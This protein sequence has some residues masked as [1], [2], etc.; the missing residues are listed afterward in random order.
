[1]AEG[2]CPGRRHGGAVPGPLASRARIPAAANGKRDRAEEL[3]QETFYRATR[4]GLRVRK[5][6]S[7]AGG[8]REHRGDK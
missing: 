1:M 6:V 8:T 5:S 3:A 7:G 4:A 2:G